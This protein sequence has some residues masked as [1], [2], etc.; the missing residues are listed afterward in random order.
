MSQL[1]LIPQSKKS[2]EDIKTIK[3][4]LSKHFFIQSLSEKNKEDI[5]NE[6]HLAK[7]GS[8]KL[9]CLQGREGKFFYILK[10]GIV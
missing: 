1:T 10:N 6:I 4:A 8:N 5:I 2:K 3:N 9:V 7:I